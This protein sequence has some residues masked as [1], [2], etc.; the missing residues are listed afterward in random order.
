LLINN[1]TVHLW[2]DLISSR[3]KVETFKI[4]IMSSVYRDK[5][6]S[7]AETEMRELEEKKVN[8]GWSQRDAERYEYLRKELHLW[9]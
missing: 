5:W 7:E 4:S 3:V 1:Q 9:K 6:E 2:R 8:R